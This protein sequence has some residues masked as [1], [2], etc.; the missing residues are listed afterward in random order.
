MQKVIFVTGLHRSGTTMLTFMLGA[1]PDCIAMGE[2]DNVISASR[3]K[4]WVESHFDK[5][6]C[7][8]CEFWPAVMAAIEQEAC[9]AYADRY[10]IF[11][12]VFA[13]FFPGKIVV[14]SS[15][16]IDACKAVQ[17]IADTKVVKITRDYRGWSFSHHK[18]LSFKGAHAW[19]RGNRE[20]DKHLKIDAHMSYEGLVFEP[21][22]ELEKAC[23]NIELLFSDEMLE[24]TGET[25]HV[26]IGNRMR[27][28]SDRRLRYDTRW[29]AQNSIG[30]G[31]HLPAIA[32][33]RDRVYP[34]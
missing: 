9:Q 34:S 3:D 25:D 24:P 33:N 22:S 6:T 26:L 13:E 7:G 21:I 5:C 28:Q 14:D 10:R 11:L 23:S 15:K 1:H 17:G 4:S 31:L 18:K 20:I 8:Q 30:A 2:V 32:Y 16:V 27:L 12:Q 29:M 19:F